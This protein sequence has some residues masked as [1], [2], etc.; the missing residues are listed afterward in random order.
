MALHR[1]D[2]R[3]FWPDIPILGTRVISPPSALSRAHAHTYSRHSALSIFGT[4]PIPNV[5]TYPAT[6]LSSGQGLPATLN[7]PVHV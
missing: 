1:M 5:G 7:N 6:S 4:L 2:P 3:R